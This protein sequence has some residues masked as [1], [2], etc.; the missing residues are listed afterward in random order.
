MNCLQPKIPRVYT[1]IAN[2]VL[3]AV[4]DALCIAYNNS[5]L[6]N[7]ESDNTVKVELTSK[8]RLGSQMIDCITV[9]L[10]FTQRH[11]SEDEGFICL[12]V[13]RSTIVF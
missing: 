3:V 10:V 9:V 2:M 1:G 13:Q 8:R 11:V 5:T 4:C 7:D 12:Q 6:P